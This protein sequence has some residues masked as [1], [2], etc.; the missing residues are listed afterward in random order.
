MRFLFL[1]A[2]CAWPAIA[3]AEEQTPLAFWTDFCTA[4]PHAEAALDACSAT[5]DVLIDGTR[6]PVQFRVFEDGAPLCWPATT[7][8]E[9]LVISVSM[10]S[11][12]SWGTLQ[13]AVP[14]GA[15]PVA[16]DGYRTTL[17]VA[18]SQLS[19]NAPRTGPF[20]LESPPNTIEEYGARVAA[21]NATLRTARSSHDQD[22]IADATL[23]RESLLLWG[24][25]HIKRKDDSFEGGFITLG[26]GVAGFV[27]GAVTLVV[28]TVA[29]CPP[30]VSL[31]GAGCS[32]NAGL[33]TLGGLVMVV[34]GVTALASI[35]ILL[36]QRASA[37][38]HARIV[39]GPARVGLSVSF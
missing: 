15:S 10:T 25:R 29:S 35:P 3:H 17:Q 6:H 30:G 8:S 33:M 23:K 19:A 13:L 9:A 32:E 26:A 21:L 12:A 27:A 28:G 39:V 7:R 24:S 31:A 22:T 14:A 2:V 5:F 1:V 18:S 34:G 36:S 37:R 11:H 4:K 20:E 16:V 38:L